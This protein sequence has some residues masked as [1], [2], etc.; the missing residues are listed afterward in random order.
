MFLTFLILTIVCHYLAL[1]LSNGERIKEYQMGTIRKTLYYSAI[2]GCLLCG[3]IL[4]LWILGWIWYYFCGGFL[5]FDDMFGP[6]PFWDKVV[7]GLIS[8]VPLGVV[9]G[10]IALAS[11][12]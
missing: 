6:V 2:V 3:L 11:S 1:F 4:F 8:A 9:L 10:L 5:I 7:Y 12:K